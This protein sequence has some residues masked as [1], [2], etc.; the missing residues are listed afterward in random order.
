LWIPYSL[1]AAGMSLLGV[2]IVVQIVAAI[3][4]RPAR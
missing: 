4:D 1:M 2:Q 3:F